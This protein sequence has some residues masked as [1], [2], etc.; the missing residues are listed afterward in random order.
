MFKES[1]SIGHILLMPIP[2]KI[3]DTCRCRYRCGLIGTSL[4][5]R[6]WLL[7]HGMLHALGIRKFLAKTNIVV[8]EQP[9][10]FPHLAAC[11]FLL[12]PKCKKVIKETH[13][14]DS[15]AI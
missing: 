1:A 7:H 2:P 3:A 6:S 13:F 9:P 4:E 10:C 12:F 15:T 8:L 14:Q 5:T 11:D